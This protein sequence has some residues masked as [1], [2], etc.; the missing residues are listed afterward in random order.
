MEQELNRQSLRALDQRSRSLQLYSGSPIC[1]RALDSIDVWQIDTIHHQYAVAP[2]NRAYFALDPSG[3]RTLVWQ[4]GKHV[5]GSKT[6]VWSGC[7]PRILVRVGLRLTR[8]GHC[9]NYTVLPDLAPGIVRLV[10]FKPLAVDNFVVVLFLVRHTRS[11]WL[12]NIKARSLWGA[13]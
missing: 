10:W 1:F 8:G 9:C 4:V 2:Q 12:T 13:S 6:Y 3:V 7:F 5:R 11:L